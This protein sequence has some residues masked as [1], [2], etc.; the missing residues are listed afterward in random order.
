MKTFLK[1]QTLTYSAAVAVSLLFSPLHAVT[2]T[3]E[4]ISELISSCPWIGLI[5]EKVSYGPIT[6]SKVDIDDSGKLVFC[7]PGEL[8][9]GTLR[10]RIDTDRL[11]S[12]HLHHII[13]GLRG[14]NAQNCI[15]HSFGIWDSKGSSSFS[16]Y[17]PEEQG[18]Y[19]LC[20]DY[21]KC[22]LCSHAIEK[23]QD[24]PPSHKT[25]IGIVIV[26]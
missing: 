24:N 19:E 16:F 1:L 20:F 12:G 3:T 11:D 7:R 9:E 15:S 23:W 22:T 2:S 17:A 25:T 8:I 14:Q 10:Y 4:R 18:L 26:E 5:A 13:V 6:V 21:E